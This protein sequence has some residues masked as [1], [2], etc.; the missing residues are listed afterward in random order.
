MPKKHKDRYLPSN[1]LENRELWAGL[2]ERYEGF[3]HHRANTCN[4]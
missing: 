3:W 4:T 1:L 2:T